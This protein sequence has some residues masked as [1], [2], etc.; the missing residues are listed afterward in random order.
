MNVKTITVEYR[1]V[2]ESVTDDDNGR[3]GPSGVYYYTAEGALEA[4][5]PGTWTGKGYDPITRQAIV[6]KTGAYLLTPIF[7]NNTNNDAKRRAALAK[8]TLEERNLLGLKE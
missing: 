1:E 8:L 7:I 3:N 4:S 5:K 2:F 6:D